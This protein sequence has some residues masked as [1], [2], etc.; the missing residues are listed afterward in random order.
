MLF[1]YIFLCEVFDLFVGLSKLQNLSFIAETLLKPSWTALSVWFILSVHGFYVTGHQPT[2]S[3][4]HWSAAFVGFTGD[5]GGSNFF[6][7]LLVGFNTFMAQILFG[8]S[9]PLIVLAPLAIGVAFP[10]LRGNR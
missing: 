10:R 5:W 7:A 3:S 4:L 6:P 1:Y 9:L 2:F 8:L